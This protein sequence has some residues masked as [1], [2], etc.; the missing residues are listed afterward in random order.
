[1]DRASRRSRR[2]SLQGDLEQFERG[3][4]LHH[5]VHWAVSFLF[6]SSCLLNGG[7][8]LW[9]N[10][11]VG[12]DV[13]TTLCLTEECPTPTR[14]KVFSFTLKSSVEAMWEA[15]AYYV[16][17]FIISASAVWPYVKMLAM[18]GA[19]FWPVSAGG[20]RRERQRGVVARVLDLAGK[21]SLMDGFIMIL[22]AAGFNF[23]IGPFVIGPVTLPITVDVEVTT[24]WAVTGGMVASAWSAMQSHLL[25]LAHYRAGEGGQ[26]QQQR[27]RQ[28]PQRGSSDMSARLLASGY[29]TLG[30]EDRSAQRAAG[31]GRWGGVLFGATTTLLSVATLVVGAVGATEYQVISYEFGGFAGGFV[32]GDG[33]S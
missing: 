14:T 4:S 19:W 30:A 18:V 29:Q 21:W 6:V 13:W 16:A 20:S 24:E 26:Q 22:L 3:R 25:L 11:S 32:A 7:L 10:L 9:S 33:P 27:R 12:A 31:C 17:V 2:D 28:P 23:K 15:Q 1:M 8:F 5:S